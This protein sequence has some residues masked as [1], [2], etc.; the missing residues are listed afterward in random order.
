MED[1]QKP[2]Y[3]AMYH[4]CIWVSRLITKGCEEVVP[5]RSRESGSL[6]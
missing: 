1:D 5:P 6:L 4:E 2:D 3:E